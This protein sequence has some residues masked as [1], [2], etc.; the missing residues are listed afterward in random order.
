MVA[1]S[2][3]RPLSRR[4][5]KRLSGPQGS[6]ILGD[7]LTFHH[8]VVEWDVVLIEGDERLLAV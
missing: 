6:E 7:A 2:T 3:T 4:I 5:G 1:S 8:P